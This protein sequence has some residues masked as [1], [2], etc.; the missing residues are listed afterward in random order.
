MNVT[1]DRPV[2]QVVIVDRVVTS[3]TLTKRTELTA[4][5]KS[6]QAQ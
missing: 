5:V 3:V 1:I 6:L 2:I 4:T